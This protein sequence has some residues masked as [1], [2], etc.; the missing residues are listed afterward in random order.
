M[1]FKDKKLFMVYEKVF[2]HFLEIVKL[3]E[4]R[5]EI[6]SNEFRILNNIFLLKIKIKIFNK[7]FEASW[8]FI[9]EQVI[10]HDEFMNDT[11]YFFRKFRSIGFNNSFEKY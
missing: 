4:L 8:L 1:L 7:F 6:N 5:E 9:P 3:N 10:I 2:R 11:L